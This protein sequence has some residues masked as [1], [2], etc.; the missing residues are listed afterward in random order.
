MVE[1]RVIV[2]RARG[3]QEA[4]RITEYRVRRTEERGETGAKV[5]IGAELLCKGAKVEAGKITEYG[6]R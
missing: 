4:E 1:I 5:Q 6:G 3:N 2:V